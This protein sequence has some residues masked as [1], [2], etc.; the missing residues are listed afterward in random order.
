MSW[1]HDRYYARSIR[2]GRRVI[3]D[4][5]G[6]G[7]YA[8]DAFRA[9]EAARE[10]RLA[11]RSERLRLEMLEERVMTFAAA[12]DVLVRAALIARGYHQH[13]RGQ[14]RKKRHVA[15]EETPA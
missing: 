9:D 6:L 10:A 2:R 15:Q 12:L 3:T 4:Y 13:D 5:I 7:P 14:W 11:W 8:E 1:Q